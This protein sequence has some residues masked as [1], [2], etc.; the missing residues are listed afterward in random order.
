MSRS[1]NGKDETM[2]GI[3]NSHMSGDG[4][5][6]SGTG[7]AGVA[8]ASSTVFLGLF[9]SAQWFWL[10]TY[11]S[12]DR[13]TAGVCWSTCPI[14]VLVYEGKVKLAVRTTTDT[15]KVVTAIPR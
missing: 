9:Q 7:F 2:E 12:T 14:L 10:H 6:E 8:R 13:Q 5:Q 15:M 3:G 4:V 11:H 1:S